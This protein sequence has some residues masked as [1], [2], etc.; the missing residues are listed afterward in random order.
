[1][2]SKKDKKKAI[3]Y[4]TDLIIAIIEMTFCLLAFSFIIKDK[5]SLIDLFSISIMLLVLFF[6]FFGIVGIITDIYDA[7]ST[8]IIDEHGIECRNKYHKEVLTWNEVKDFGVFNCQCGDF[9]YQYIYFSGHR[10]LRKAKK[11]PYELAKILGIR[12]YRYAKRGYPMFLPSYIRKKRNQKKE[13]I[14]ICFRYTD[15]WW[16]YICSLDFF[17]E[18]Q[19]KRENLLEQYRVKNQETKPVQ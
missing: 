8:I 19:E 16:E 7:C 10:F 12:M 11:D 18:K 1:M 9:H 6:L 15:E 13:D 5:D 3:S 4:T 2:K 14:I 17:K